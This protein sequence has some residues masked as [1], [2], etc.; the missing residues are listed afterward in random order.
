[1]GHL[2]PLRPSKPGAINPSILEAASWRVGQ[3]TAELSPL[4]WSGKLRH[5]WFPDSNKGVPGTALTYSLCNF[6]TLP[7]SGPRSEGGGKA[8]FAEIQDPCATH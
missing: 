6:T 1:M 2:P 4:F 7:D 5:K 3:V 8:G